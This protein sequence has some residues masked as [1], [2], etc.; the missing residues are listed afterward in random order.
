MA[1]Q[2][3]L[4]GGIT[5]KTGKAVAQYLHQAPVVELVGA[6]GNESVGQD[7]GELLEQ[8]PNGRRVYS[9]IPSALAETAAD[10]YVDFTTPEAGEIHL[11]EA[12]ACGLGLLVGTTGLKR[13]IVEELTARVERAGGFA[14]ITS[15]FSIGVMVMAQAAKMLR[16]YFGQSNVQIIET[17]HTTKVDQ[18]SGTALYLQKVICDEPEQSVPIQSRRVA[19]RV[20]RHQLVACVHGEIL[21][22]T[23]EVTDPTAFGSGVLYVLEQAG[24]RSGVYHDLASFVQEVEKS[25][26]T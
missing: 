20:S 5:G 19:E 10:V 11:R 16:G 18:P 12:A 9:D 13:E 4:M 8:K 17:H 23:H 1:V 24:G 21:T 15:N 26:L 25:K 22:L 2:R 7:I 6:I 3:V 14:M